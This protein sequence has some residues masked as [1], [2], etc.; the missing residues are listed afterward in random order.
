MQRRNPLFRLTAVDPDKEPT[1][2]RTNGIRIYNAAMI[3]ADGRRVMVQSTDEAEIA[4]GV[5]RVLRER[6]ITVC[7]IEG[8][9]ELPM[10]NFEFHTH[11]EGVAGHSHDDAS[12]RL[13]QMAG[14][15]V[16]RFRRALEA[17]G[18]E[19]RQ[20]ILAT[21]REVPGDCTLV[22]TA[23]PRT[24]FLPGESAALRTYLAQGGAALF[25]FDLGFVLEP[26][27]AR[28][29]DDLGVR[30]EQQVVV[31]P[32]SHYMTDAEMVA[33]TGYD[34]HPITQSAS[35][36]FYP[37][38]R[39]LTLVKPAGDIRVT[40]LLMSSRDS[41]T[42]DVAPAASR[43]T[44]EPLELRRN[45]CRRLA[46]GARTARARRRSRRPAA[47]RQPAIAR[48]R[49]RR[50]R[51]REQLVLSLHVEQRSVAC[52]RPLARTRGAHHSRCHP[53][54]GPVA[55]AA[56]AE[57]GARGVRPCGRS[58]AAHGHRAGRTGVVAAPMTRWRRIAVPLAVTF[59]VGY[60]AV[61]VMSGEQP[62]QRQFVE[63]EAKG[64]LKIPP[65]Q[66]RRVELV[67]A[68]QHLSLLRQGEDNW[69][70]PGGPGIDGAV[71]RQISTAVRMM[72]NSGPAR[73]IPA[74]DLKDTDPAEF[75][76]DV[77]RITASFYL[78]RCRSCAHR[79]FWRPQS[80]RVSPIHADR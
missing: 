67:R 46:A 36:T 2:A 22:V 18:Y 74:D 55:R 31:D 23:N 60:L 14:H 8:H 54:P 41:Y 73:E 13:V 37:G 51:L 61:M 39:P 33:V 9:N 62:T 43:A 26:G 66:V 6:V 65:E 68:D 56:D 64:V 25:L 4:L 45:E 20:L 5:Q 44:D 79:P 71:A 50:L 7:F 78:S 24:T 17:Q 19:A 1:V 21:S 58:A 27:L 10:D 52:R 76:L 57:P 69:V 29:T 80:R 42:R 16:G 49:D 72:H 38:I 32:L 59:V 53:N 47:G 63:F 75:G 12:S 3:E 35:L 34:P 48:R 28:L 77:P 11:L 15:G 30:P 70:T 40:P